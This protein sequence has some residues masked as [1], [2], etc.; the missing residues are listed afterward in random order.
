MRRVADVVAS[1]LVDAG[2]RDVF[3]LPGGGAMYLNDGIACEPRL[4]PVPCHHE[5]SCGIAAEAYGR[6]GGPRFGVAIVTTGPGATNV[7][8][9]VAGAWI[10]SLPL[11]V[12]SGQVKRADALNGRPLRQSGV[13]E[14]EA[15]DMV[16][17]VT[18]FAT[19]VDEPTAIVAMLNEAKYWMLEGR[20]GPVWVE[21]PLDVQAA[22]VDEDGLK[23]FVAPAVKTSAGQMSE[24]MPKLLALISEASRPLILAGHGVRIAGASDVFVRAV[25]SLGIPC[26]FTWNASD[27]LP[28]DHP[29]YVGRPG[30]VAAR[31]ANFAVQNADL[32]ITVGARLDNVVTAYNPKLF[33]RGAKKVI[34][35]VDRHEIEKHPFDPDL[36]I[37]AN[38]LEFLN[39]LSETSMSSGNQL[40]AWRERCKSWK[41]EFLPGDRPSGPRA[42]INHKDPSTQE[43]RLTHED[44]VTHIEFVESLSDAVPE[45]ML[46]VTGSSGLAVEFF[47]TAF[48]NKPG[49]RFFLTSGLGAMGYGLPA[50]IGACMG[51][52]KKPTICIES[53][54]S[55]MLNVQE[56]ATVYALNLPI[57][58]IVMNNQGYASI[59]NTQRN[60]FAARYIGSNAQS[61]LIIPN[62][63]SIASS[64]G[65]ES[66]TAN[67]TEA[68]KA[69]IHSLDFQGPKLLDFHLIHDEQLSPKVAALPQS[70]GSILSMP[71][72]DMSPLLALEA[73]EAQMSLPLMPQSLKARQA[74]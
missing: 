22:P 47:Y 64:F 72:E 1:W 67:T 19:R 36:S 24:S 55:L 34:V 27:L 54:G 17:G 9:P 62:L 53:D 29:L 28:W 61:Q 16:R 56:L 10:E 14:V 20:P 65:V 68:L 43:D 63:A 4:N 32:L 50:A 21:V 51:A 73:L 41:Q 8:T 12:I 52:G 42:H 2:I 59:R 46:L 39:A 60:Y 5:Q 6:V 48:R 57:A 74:T 71:L 49:Q 25:E 44:P 69:F 31:G 45:N 70:D 23:Q 33:A 3:L 7:L 30:T 13:Q 37:Q 35:D 11:M 40:T 15:L 26:V 18:K 58:I 38:A 66:H